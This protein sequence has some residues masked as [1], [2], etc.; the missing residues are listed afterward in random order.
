MLRFEWDSVKATLNERKHGISFALAEQAFLD[1]NAL[2]NLDR[3]EPREYRWKTLGMVQGL[4]LLL[5]AHTY[6]EED[7]DEVIR[8]IS[9][10]RA[11]SKEKKLYE[12]T[13]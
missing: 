3:V 1:P 12:T 4:L 6:I 8:I 9:A 2:M 5:V 13:F 7:G 11:D 10:R